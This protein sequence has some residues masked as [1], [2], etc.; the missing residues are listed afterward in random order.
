MILNEYG[1]ENI[2]GKNELIITVKE[3]QK[4]DAAN[5]KAIM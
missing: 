2:S 5:F 1:D 4:C 3:K